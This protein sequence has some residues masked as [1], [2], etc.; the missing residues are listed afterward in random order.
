[1]YPY[2]RLYDYEP[3]RNAW[4]DPEFIYYFVEQEEVITAPLN[5]VERTLYLAARAQWMDAFMSPEDALQA[6]GELTLPLC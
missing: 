3:R 2:L 6:W 4:I 5:G 1:M